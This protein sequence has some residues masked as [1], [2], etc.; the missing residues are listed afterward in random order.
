MNGLVNYFLCG[1]FFSGEFLGAITELLGVYLEHIRRETRFL[2]T[3][4]YSCFYFKSLLVEYGVL[5]LKY[6]V[7][8]LGRAR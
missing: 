1:M 7:L 5:C 2:D 4:C 3:F 6:V 8:G